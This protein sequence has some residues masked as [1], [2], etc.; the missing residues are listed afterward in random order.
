VRKAIS[1]NGDTVA[2]NHASQMKADMLER[3]ESRKGKNGKAEREKK[4]DVNFFSS[5]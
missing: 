1:K 3:R 2:E 4:T 5:R